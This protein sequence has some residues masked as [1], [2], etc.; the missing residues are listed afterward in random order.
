MPILQANIS[1]VFFVYKNHAG[2]Q[3]VHEPADD[4]DISFCPRSFCL[5]NYQKTTFHYIGLYDF[6][7]LYCLKLPVAFKSSLNWD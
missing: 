1:V 3:W 4:W 5:F 2:V 7:K 6:S